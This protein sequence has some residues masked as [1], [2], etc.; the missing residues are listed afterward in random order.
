MQSILKHLGN[1]KANSVM[2]SWNSGFPVL[3]LFLKKLI[4]FFLT[5]VSHVVHAVGKVDLF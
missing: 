3:V 4:T 5:V 2:N 1:R